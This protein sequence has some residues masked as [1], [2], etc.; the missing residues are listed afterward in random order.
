MGLDDLA[1]LYL[2]ALEDSSL[3]I[4]RAD[5]GRVAVAGFSAG[6]NLALALSQL[7]IRPEKRGLSPV[8]C[9]PKAVISIYGALDFSR[10]PADKVSSRHY[11]PGLPVPR[12]G[13]KD[14]LLSMAPL[15]DWCYLPEEQDLRDPLVSPG[16]YVKADDLPPHV[17][18]IAS[19]LDMLAGDSLTCATRLAQSRGSLTGDTSSA[20]TPCGRPEP[21]KP[22]E[23]ELNDKRFAWQETFEKGSVNWMLVPDV[24]HG[25]DNLV[26]RLRSG[27]EETVKDAEKKTTAYCKILGEW[28]HSTVFK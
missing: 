9:P 6:G 5:G 4:D 11:K 22:G 16:P 15:F 12:N 13:D 20:A 14:M 17:Y 28:L 8:S 10:A 18:I 1:A 2:A 24:L 26:G 27:G 25:F 23:L 3:P 19:E 21:G 7:L